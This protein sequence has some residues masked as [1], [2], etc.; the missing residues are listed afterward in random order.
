MVLIRCNTANPGRA[1]GKWENIV[2]GEQ[3]MV[4]K[5]YGVVI[6]ARRRGC[7]PKQ[8][9]NYAWEQLLKLVPSCAEHAHA[10]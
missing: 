7:V 6:V 2:E 1:D 5:M 8:T 9:H 10:Y 4:L 3:G